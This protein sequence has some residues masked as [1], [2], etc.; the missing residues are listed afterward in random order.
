MTNVALRRLV[1]FADRETGLEA[2]WTMSA[3]E[4]TLEEIAF[5][6][7][8]RDDIQRFEFLGTRP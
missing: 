3:I 1:R 5:D 4:A 2:V 7:T 6:T 8:R